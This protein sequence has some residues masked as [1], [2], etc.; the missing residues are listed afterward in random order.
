MHHSTTSD[1][2]CTSRV[3]PTSGTVWMRRGRRAGQ[4]CVRIGLHKRLRGGWQHR[5]HMRGQR[6]HVDSVVPGP[7]RHM[8]C[9]SLRCTERVIA[10]DSDQRL[11]SKRGDGQQQLHVGVCERLLRERRRHRHMLGRQRAGDGVVPGSGCDVHCVRRHCQLCGTGDMQQRRQRGVLCV[12]GGFCGAA[13]PAQRR[14][15]LRR[16]WRGAGRRQLRVR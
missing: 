2:Q 11:R 12:R 13:V 10:A 3:I 9:R 5:R 7:E 1:M 8:H 4:R 6:R 14:Q 15:Y 16:C